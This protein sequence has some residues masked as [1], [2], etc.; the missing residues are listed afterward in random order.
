M[1]IISVGWLNYHGEQNTH[2]IVCY[3]GEGH[4]K[5]FI[6]KICKTGGKFEEM[7]ERHWERGGEIHGSGLRGYNLGLAKFL[8]IHNNANFF[9][10]NKLQIMVGGGGM[11]GGSGGGVKFAMRM[12]VV[13]VVDKLYPTLE[14]PVR[15]WGNFGVKRIFLDFCGCFLL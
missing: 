5:P 14:Y 6:L 4:I 8:Q 10:F 2:K 12:R 13:S 11:G 3:T 7:E 15:K 9:C 1:G